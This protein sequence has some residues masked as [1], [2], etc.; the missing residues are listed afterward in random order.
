[1]K[2]YNVGVV[3]IGL[4]GS[5][6]VR[7]L[8]QRKFPAGQVRIFATREREEEINGKKYRI[9]VA[10]DNS[11]KGLDVVLFA[12]TEGSKGASKQWG[13]KAVESGAYV[14][15]NG[16]DFRM[17]ERCPLVVPEVNAHHLNKNQR[18]IANPNCSTIQMVVALAPLHR[19]AKI[20]RVIVSTY[21]SV[22]GTG[23][24]GVQELYEQAKEAS[25]SYP[26]IKVKSKP[27][28]YPHQIAFNLIPQISTLSE[29]PGFAN[30]YKEEVK[31]VRE[32]RKILDAPGLK[33]T[34]TCVRAPVF[35]AHSESINVEFEKKI[36]VSEARKIL[37]GAPGV[38][39]LDEPE[40]S[41]YPMPLEA[42][43][44][45]ETFVGRI[46]EDVSCPNALD[47]WVV[48]DNIRKGAASNA[49]QIAETLVSKQLL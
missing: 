10:N 24:A 30:Y 2:K 40:K 5:E 17:D 6:M 26:E 46:R 14:I 45:D 35:W 3:G 7:V 22:S 42:A 48:S 44:R 15:D 38:V 36:T 33:V 47:I 16:D 49:V 9:E 27:S 21:Q 19:H 39:L 32:T 11:F 34:A 29:D 25:A 37:S 8:E 23:R 20:K 31:M 1:M 4:V 12:G 18:F 41:V 13:W 28:A 43:G